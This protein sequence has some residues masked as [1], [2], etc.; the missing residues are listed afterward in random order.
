MIDHETAE[1]LRGLLS[2]L[3]AAIYEDSGMPEDSQERLVTLISGAGFHL[4]DE[5]ED[6]LR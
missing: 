2:D 3:Q 5:L 4:I 6:V 1:R